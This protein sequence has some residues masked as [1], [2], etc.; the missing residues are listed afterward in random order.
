MYAKV[1]GSNLLCQNFPLLWFTLCNCFVLTVI[2]IQESARP[3]V[4]RFPIEHIMS[5]QNLYKI[6]FMVHGG[7][8]VIR[9]FE[10]AKP[11]KKY[12]KVSNLVNFVV[13]LK[14]LFLLSPFLL[15]NNDGGGG[16]FAPKS[17]CKGTQ[18]YP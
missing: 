13:F 5:C 10:L 7:R 16:A 2:K 9:D 12:R 14:I 15:L 6:I 1:C 18:I 17:L 11:S 3:A 8:G 4:S